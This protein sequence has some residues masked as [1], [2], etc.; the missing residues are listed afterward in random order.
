MNPQLAIAALIF[1][2][3][4][5]GGAHA[6]GKAKTAVNCTVASTPERAATIVKP[7]S[8]I[9][10]ANRE[11]TITLNN[12]G[13]RI[14]LT[15]NGRTEVIQRI[16][17]GFEPTLVAGDKLLG[18]LPDHLQHYKAK[19][20]VLYVSTIRTTGGGGGGQCGAGTEIYLKVLD[21]KPA[22]PSIIA[23]HLIGSCSGIELENFDQSNL[24]LGSISIVDGQIVMK[25]GYYR[26]YQGEPTATVSRD[27]KHL[28]FD[29]APTE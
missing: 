2:S 21:L 9:C 1:L 19:K 5:F 22:R 12:Q 24:E 25:F 17:K 8:S 16:P 13:N 27:F 18:F 3:A 10:A 4:T 26:G 29:S 23:K 14:S 11:Y 15:S 7:V 28:K 6:A 20:I